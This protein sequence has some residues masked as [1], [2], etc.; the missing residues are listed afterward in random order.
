MKF[1]FY[2]AEGKIELYV[3]KYFRLRVNLKQYHSIRSL[4]SIKFPFSIKFLFNIKFLYNK[5][6]R[7]NGK[8]F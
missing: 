5:F 6:S 1:S 2:V 7:Y 4:F 8:W 3:Q